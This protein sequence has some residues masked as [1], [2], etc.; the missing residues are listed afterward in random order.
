MI[1][2]PANTH[3]G[4]GFRARNAKTPQLQV[5]AGNL[6]AFTGARSACKTSNATGR[7]NSNPVA[8]RVVASE[9]W[10]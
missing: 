5:N 6:Q 1:F 10:E 2:A 9:Q 8:T 4:A 7:Q 3:A